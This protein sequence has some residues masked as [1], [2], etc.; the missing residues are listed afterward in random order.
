M[1]KH[2]VQVLSHGE[3]V[4]MPDLTYE[5]HAYPDM[6]DAHVYWVESHKHTSGWSV[7]MLKLG[8]Q[9]LMQQ[10]AVNATAC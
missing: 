5:V 2:D 3:T 8:P 9:S 4:S 7:P 1:A 6:L 10:V